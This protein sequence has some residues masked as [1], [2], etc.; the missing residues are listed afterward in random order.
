M[1]PIVIRN[2]SH[3]T[4]SNENNPQSLTKIES[5]PAKSSL[6]N[7]VST[8][9][10]GCFEEE[11]VQPVA[12][13][14][15]SLKFPQEAT[16]PE[17][18]WNMLVQ[19]RCSMTEWPKERLN[20]DAFYHPDGNRPDTIPFRGGHFLEEALGNFDAPFFSIAAAEAVAI[21][22]QQRLL[23]ETAYRALENGTIVNSGISPVLISGQL[24]YLWK[25][26]R[27]PKLPY[28]RDAFPMIIKRA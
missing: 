10:T 12:I 21:D 1:A 16:S 18:F 13:V 11:S 22:P 19:K 17:A 4:Q 25:K 27:A 15:F 24:A 20:L 28:I 26:P 23:L 7:G 14:G 5:P 3:I 8:T 2:D 6:A 9:P